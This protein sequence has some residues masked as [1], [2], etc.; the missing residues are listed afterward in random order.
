[1][2]SRSQRQDGRLGCRSL[3]AAIATKSVMIANAIRSFVSRSV[4]SKLE[5]SPYPSGQIVSAHLHAAT[6]VVRHGGYHS[7]GEIDLQSPCKHGAATARH[8]RLFPNI[9][10]AA[11][12][13]PAACQ[14]IARTLGNCLSAP[15]LR[16]LCAAINGGRL[17]ELRRDWAVIER[18][19]DRCR[20]V[21]QCIAPKAANIALPWIGLR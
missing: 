7:V 19:S 3:M 12:I 4:M 2:L 15:N 13:R 17:V 5:A 6:V 9:P 16:R 21:H 14:G 11:A 10:L 8:A 1:M 20:Q 18:A